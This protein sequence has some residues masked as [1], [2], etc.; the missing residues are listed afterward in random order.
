MVGLID[1]AVYHY[2]QILKMEDYVEEYYLEMAAEELKELASRLNFK[3]DPS[4]QKIIERL[5][6]TSQGKIRSMSS[7]KIALS[8]KK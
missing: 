4:I 2:Q 1:D 8:H 6:S 3:L 5:N 7:F